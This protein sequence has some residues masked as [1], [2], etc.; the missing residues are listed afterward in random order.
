MI[1]SVSGGVHKV[2]TPPCAAANVSL[3]IEPLFSSPGSR[4]RARISTKPG[5]TIQLFAS[6]VDFAWKPAGAFPSEMILSFSIYKS[7]SLS[8][9]LAGSITRPFFICIPI[10]IVFL[11]YCRCVCC[12]QPLRV[13]VRAPL[14]SRPY[15]RQCHWSPGPV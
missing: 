2:V 10:T 14:T 7:V 3:S 8:T 1:G 12:C 13:N 5:Q 15:A 4:S 9:L 6:I 11:Q